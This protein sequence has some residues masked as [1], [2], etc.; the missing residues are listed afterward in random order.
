M[1]NSHCNN[2][3]KKQKKNKKICGQL[4]ANSCYSQE[5]MDQKSTVLSTRLRNSAHIILSK[6][7]KF[8]Y[9]HRRRQC[10]ETR[11]ITSVRCHVPSGKYSPVTVP[12]LP[13]KHKPR[14]AQYIPS[15]CQLDLSD[16]TSDDFELCLLA[17]SNGPI[18]TGRSLLTGDAVV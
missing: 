1:L 16:L 8:A 13:L 2:N 17:H 7:N 15:A 5:Y 10:D 12:P 3:D 6:S 14:I 9:Y 18:S 4:D 11:S